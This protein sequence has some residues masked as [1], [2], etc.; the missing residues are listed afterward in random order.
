MNSF[1]Y[2]E[3]YKLE[4]L[5]GEFVNQETLKQ[6]KQEAIR[7]FRTRITNKIPI[8]SDYLNKVLQE[9]D[10]GIFQKEAMTNVTDAR[11]RLMS[12]VI[13]AYFQDMEQVL[14]QIWEILLKKGDC[15]I[16]VDQSAYAGVLI[17][18][19]QIL[20]NLA[21]KIG[22]SVSQ[23]IR[24]RRATTSGQQLKMA[25]HLNGNLRESIIVLR[26]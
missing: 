9:L 4:N 21:E 20:A 5:L 22:F 8:H 1:D 25:P 12:K 26:K 17:P 10:N 11:T 7:N 6:R 13:P 18:T 2:F 3:S 23:I 15:F 19:D 16:V 24:C 14:R